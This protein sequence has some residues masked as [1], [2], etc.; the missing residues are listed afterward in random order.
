MK[1]W[2]NKVFDFDLLEHANA[3]FSKYR[4]WFHAY[5]IS[6]TVIIVVYGAKLFFQNYAMDDYSRFF[7]DLPW[8]DQAPFH[9]RW[10]CSA[11][12]ATLF[13]GWR[14]ILPYTNTLFSL[15]L[16]SFSGL[17]VGLILRVEDKLILGVLIC[18]S[19]ISPYWV[20]NLYFNTNATV[21]IGVLFS[22]L[23]VYVLLKG[24]KFIPVSILL[25]VFAVGIYQT[26]LQV[27]I[28][29]AIGWFL[30]SLL[31]VK[32]MRALRRLIV[33]LLLIV[34]VLFVS[35]IFSAL[36]NDFIV[37]AFTSGEVYKRY[38][39]SKNVGLGEIFENIWGI[40]DKKNPTRVKLPFLSSTTNEM[41]LF[42]FLFGVL[43]YSI[44]C[45]SSRMRGLSCIRFVLFLF[46]IFCLVLVLQLPRI[47]GLGVPVRAYFPMATLLVL[48][49][50]FASRSK[51]KLIK[52][53]GFVFAIIS[54]LVSVLY[55]SYFYDST[56]RQTQADIIR[57]NQIVSQ[58]RA[59]ERFV[60]KEEVVP[61]FFIIGEKRFPMSGF[62]H[63]YQALQ[64]SWSKY[65]IFDHF[66]DFEFKKI[67]S[68]KEE[69]II[70]KLSLI[71]DVEEYPSKGSIQLIDDVIV[72]VLD[73]SFVKGESHKSEAK[74]SI[75]TGNVWEVQELDY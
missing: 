47:L 28:M 5:F 38:A 3:F 39:Y 24:F 27:A 59:D 20:H 29:L 56:S 42:V 51:I 74:S 21:S 52:S 17:I 6:L 8:F 25:M 55:V 73:D 18:L 15:I 2:M 54:L 13:D 65:A 12:N 31:E 72:L 66:T 68:K 1:K 16:I 58:I 71:N 11:L 75:P 40:F 67:N 35:Y 33:R 60:Y 23:S 57:V 44:S 69:I 61:E 9:G 4:D 50:V 7:Q 32:E 34:L 36:I 26:V 53:L 48:S 14:H 70:S 19:V 45:F 63:R 64:M 41:N 37:E 30:M 46:A 49:F 43:G 22:V 10:A 62:S